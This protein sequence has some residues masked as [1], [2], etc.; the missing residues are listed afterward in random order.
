[1]LFLETRTLTPGAAQTDTSPP[2]MTILLAYESDMLGETP[3]IGR[4][5]T[6]SG[7]WVGPT[8]V[9]AEDVIAAKTNVIVPAISHAD[10]ENGPDTS[11][12][13]MEMKYQFFL[14]IAPTLEELPL[15]SHAREVD[16]DNKIMLGMDADGLFSVV[17]SNRVP[18]AAGGK[19]TAFLIS[20]EGHQDHLPTYAPPKSANADQS[21][22]VVVLGGWEFTAS[23]M[24]GKLSRANAGCRK[25]RWCQAATSTREP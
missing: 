14:D 9:P 6:T 25:Q 16:T 10:I 3:N 20:L 12:Q 2:W 15:L 23:K 4:Y 8:T 18:P 19:C 1:M 5:D 13:I 11:A 7:K 21:I 17:V 22:R 24:P